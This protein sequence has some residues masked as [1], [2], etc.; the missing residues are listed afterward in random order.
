MDSF[1][2]RK[3]KNID[4]Y[5]MDSRRFILN[6]LKIPV[7]AFINTNILSQKNEIKFDK[8]I[9]RNIMLD[10]LTTSQN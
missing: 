7:A 2:L 3:L 10:N 8:M 9:S 1:L 5:V 4:E 6:F